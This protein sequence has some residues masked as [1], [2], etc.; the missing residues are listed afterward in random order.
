MGILEFG[1]VL[2]SLFSRRGLLHTLNDPTG[3]MSRFDTFVALEGQV[4]P[5]SVG[6][7]EVGVSSFQ[8]SSHEAGSTARLHEVPRGLHIAD[9]PSHRSCRGKFAGWS[10]EDFTVLRSQAINKH[11]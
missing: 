1:L 9:H 7:F 2:T 10:C 11:A 5:Q 3:C 8:L 4:L 6:S